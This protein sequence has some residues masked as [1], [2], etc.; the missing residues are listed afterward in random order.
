[1]RACLGPSGLVAIGGELADQ[2]LHGF[3][4]TCEASEVAET[5]VLEKLVHHHQQQDAD[6]HMQQ[7]P[8]LNLVDL[9]TRHGEN[10]KQVRI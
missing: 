5:W 1:M 2:L 6:Q 4:V 3:S 7:E 9:M 8:T 10:L